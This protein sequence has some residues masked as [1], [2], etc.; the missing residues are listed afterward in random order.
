[1]KLPGI[2]T[3][4]V[5][6]IL[7]RVNSL[8]ELMSLKVEDLEELLGS[9]ENAKD[10]YQ[11]LHEKLHPSDTDPKNSVIFHKKGKSG[12]PDGSRFKSKRN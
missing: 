3:R 8:L 4:N 9:K 10:V 6:G 7:N 2:T 12:K 1:M 11:A 5:F